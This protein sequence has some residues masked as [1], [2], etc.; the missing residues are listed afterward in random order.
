MILGVGPYAPDQPDLNGSTSALALNVIAAANSYRPLPSLSAVT[1]ALT[2]RGQGGFYARK[3]DGSAVQFMGDATKLYKLSGTTPVDVSR[4]S[5]GAYA[6]PADGF[7]QFCQFGSLVIAINGA[8]VAQKFNIESD[9]NFSALGG[10]PPASPKFSMVVGDFVVF[11]HT[12]NG[13]TY[14]EWSGINNAATW[15]PSSTTLADNQQ[16][17]DGGRIMGC[18]GGQVGYI[19]QEKAI[20]RMSFVG[21]PLVFQFDKIHDNVGGAIDYCVTQAPGARVFFM[22]R[23]GPYMLI[24]DRLQDIGAE[25][26]SRT[27]WGS[28]T[29]AINQTYL[30]RTSTAINPVETLWA[31]SIASP[32]STD[33]TPDTLWLYNWTVDRWTVAQPGNHEMI[34]T[35]V[36]QASFTLEDL[37][38]LYSTLESVPFSLDSYVWTGV[39]RPVFGGFDSTHAFG[40]FNGA[41][42]AATVDT[43][44]AAIGDDRLALVRGARAL[45]DTASHTITLGTRKLQSD[46]VSWGSA[47]SPSS[48]NGM[49]YFRQ[50]ARYARARISVSAGA[51]W[52]HIQGL[53]DIDTR[54]RGYQ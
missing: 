49:C 36:T 27:F 13:N 40:Y 16:L 29:Y 4:A 30:N 8:D 1:S 6:C 53:A 46:A 18:A 45:V 5:G 47:V 9:T 54:Q 19:I 39:A 12:T 42:L 24:G 17:P 44:E 34:A 2:A 21:S 25:R 43:L 50:N 22:D 23:A 11:C 7:W 3:S 32:A 37:N 33:G 41:N 48:S 35:L 51:T 26:M 20:R 15:T 31:I 14:V 10:S 38:S 52:T 28:G